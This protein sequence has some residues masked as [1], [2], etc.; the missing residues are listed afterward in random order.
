MLS[1]AN[2]N[3]LERIIQVLPAAKAPTVSRLYNSDYFAV[4]SVVVKS[5]INLL[6]PELKRRGAEDILEIPMS[7]IVP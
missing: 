6:I 2:S 4:E 7:K 5:D 3:N 1:R